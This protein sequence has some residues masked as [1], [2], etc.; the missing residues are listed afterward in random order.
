[1]TAAIVAALPQPE[2]PPT[3][4]Q[5]TRARRLEVH[6]LREFMAMH[7][8]WRQRAQDFRRRMAVGEFDGEWPTEIVDE[9]E[10]V[11]VR[12]SGGR[13]SELHLN[14]QWAEKASVQALHDT[15]LGALEGVDLAHEDPTAAERGVLR[16]LDQRI[17]DFAS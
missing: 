13:F 14:P 4:D 1:M 2:A 17:R 10:R 15:I 6:E 7:N 16:E 5:A 3:R 11:E 12:F 9:R 8:E